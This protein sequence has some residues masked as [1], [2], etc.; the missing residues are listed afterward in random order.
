LRTH[1]Q[2][3]TE[4]RLNNEKAIETLERLGDGAFYDLCHNLKLARV[5]IEDVYD[6]LQMTFR[7][8][9]SPMEAERKIQEII[10]KPPHREI[11]PNLHAI[12]QQVA[13]KYEEA[14]EESRDLETTYEAITKTYDF[15][16]RNYGMKKTEIVRIKFDTYKNRLALVND[17]VSNV[18]PYTL[19]LKL[20][21]YA[22]TFL[23]VEDKTMNQPSVQHGLS[24][25]RRVR[26]VVQSNLELT[27]EDIRV[28]EEAYC[29]ALEQRQQQF[30]KGRV[31]N[32][33]NQL[34]NRHPTGT[35]NKC[36]LCNNSVEVHRPIWYKRCTVFPG[37]EP[38]LKVQSCCQGHHADLNGKPCPSLEARKRAQ[39]FVSSLA[40]EELRHLE[41]EALEH[42]S[43]YQTEKN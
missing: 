14:P 23:R 8:R 5:P 22:E 43:L 38:L 10:N 42:E 17:D 35:E 26:E 9:T 25:A 24:Q 30:L 6:S 16:T 31:F 29:Q 37:Q 27:E 20:V 1:S 33:G 18:A 32:T 3:V 2:F 15:L 39:Q 40:A 19:F 12:Y 36:H 21:S 41:Q 7:E 11:T 13:T 28:A 4:T 34:P